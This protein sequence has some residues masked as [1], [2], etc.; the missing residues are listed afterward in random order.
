MTQL[1]VSRSHSCT[2]IPNFAPKK[3]VDTMYLG[4]TEAFKIVHAYVYVLVGG[5]SSS[6]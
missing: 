6:D 4:Y 3:T 1:S 5:V 2:A